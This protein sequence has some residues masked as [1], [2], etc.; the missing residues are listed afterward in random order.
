MGGDKQER[1]LP[2]LGSINDFCRVSFSQ[3]FKQEVILATS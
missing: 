2:G 1:N 3:T